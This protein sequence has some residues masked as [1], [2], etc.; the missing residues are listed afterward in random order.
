MVAE[1]PHADG[2]LATLASR[3]SSLDVLR[4]FALLGILLMNVQSFSMPIAAYF[5]PTA[6]GD[7]SGLNAII[8][9]LVHVFIDQK[10]MTLFSLLFGAG[11]ILFTSRAKG[12]PATHRSTRRNSERLRVPSPESAHDV[13]RCSSGT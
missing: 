9:F 4:R 6:Y 2:P 13:H 8:W 3:I 5:N 12:I 1:A 7:F 10:F 11:I